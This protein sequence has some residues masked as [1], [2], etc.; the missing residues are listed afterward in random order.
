[1]SHRYVVTVAMAGYMPESDPV[2]CDSAASALDYIR[3]EVQRFA[4]EDAQSIDEEH[5][6]S[7]S[8]Y[9][10]YIDVLENI[11]LDRKRADVEPEWFSYSLPSDYVIEATRYTIGD[12]IGMGYEPDFG[13]VDFGAAGL[14]AP[15]DAIEG[16]ESPRDSDL[17]ITQQEASEAVA[18]LYYREAYGKAG[19]TTDVASDPVVYTYEADYHCEERA[20]ERFGFD[21][22]GFITGT[23]TEGNEVGIVAPW[24]EWYDAYEGNDHATL[25]CGTCGAVID[26]LE[27]A[28]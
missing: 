11:D 8:R 3:D 12:L 4:D 18:A 23:D 20:A 19:P 7:D 21:A 25:A 6:L 1:M 26:E 14:V 5:E 10:E 2:I 9:G 22:H 16:Y 27:L 15:S 17:L 28:S 24:D 13:D